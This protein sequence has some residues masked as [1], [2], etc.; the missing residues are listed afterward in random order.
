MLYMCLFIFQIDEETV[1]II[2]DTELSRFLPSIS[3]GAEMR[4]FCHM[5]AGD[6]TSGST[7]KGI[8]FA[9]LWTR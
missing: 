1:R 5:P 2:D 7:K 4:L 3:D 9:M 6:K 8:I